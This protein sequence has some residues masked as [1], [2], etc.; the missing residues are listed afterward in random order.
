MFY[1]RAMEVDVKKIK[2][3]KEEFAKI[4]SKEEESLY[5]TQNG[6]IKYVLLPVET[7][8]CLNKEE[9]G[10][11]ATIKILNP[12]NPNLSYEEYEE[13]RR[14]VLEV[15]DKTFKPKPEKLN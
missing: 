5:I 8:D 11:S 2:G 10:P 4:D 12:M 14:Q 3:L 6:S 7:Y 15:L 13:V 1:N 9:D